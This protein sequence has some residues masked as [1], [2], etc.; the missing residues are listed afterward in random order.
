MME[1][2][3]KFYSNWLTLQ[4]VEFA[5]TYEGFDATMRKLSIVS[6]LRSLLPKNQFMYL[7]F[8]T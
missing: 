2:S 8:Y 7:Y 1:F 5:Q 6:T 3:R 4:T